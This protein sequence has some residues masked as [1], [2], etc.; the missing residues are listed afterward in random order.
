MV[1]KARDCGLT[2]LRVSIGKE[3]KRVKVLGPGLPQSLVVE[4]VNSNQSKTLKE[5]REV[6]G[7]PRESCVLEAKTSEIAEGWRAYLCPMLL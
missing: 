1:F 7:E 2:H 5:I 3:K 4:K 6:G